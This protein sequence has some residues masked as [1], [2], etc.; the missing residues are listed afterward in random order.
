M[1][2]VCKFIM[3]MLIDLQIWEDFLVG[4]LDLPAQSIRMLLF[5]CDTWSA[6][7]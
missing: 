6:R 7:E 2:G 4:L 5:S 1:H 3:N